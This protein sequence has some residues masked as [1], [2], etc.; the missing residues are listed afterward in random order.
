MRMGGGHQSSRKAFESVSHEW[1]SS[2]EMQEDLVF[3]CR[4]QEELRKNFAARYT[5]YLY[6]FLR[7]WLW[8]Q[9]QQP[10]CISKKLNTDMPA[11]GFYTFEIEA[12]DGFRMVL[13]HDS[14]PGQGC[15]TRQGSTVG[16]DPRLKLCA[17]TRKPMLCSPYFFEISIV[18]SMFDVYLYMCMHIY[19]YIYTSTL[20]HAHTCA[21]RQTVRLTDG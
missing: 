20:A 11:G 9:V 5:G 14:C 8:Q 7:G 3:S 10:M 17:H 18:Y 1:S 13:G 15:A 6:V 4:G 2:E 21:C 19:I 12:D 16:S